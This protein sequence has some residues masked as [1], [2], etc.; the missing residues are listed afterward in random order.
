[1][2]VFLRTKMEAKLSE[3]ECDGRS[4]SKEYVSSSC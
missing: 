1:M 2:D 3:M 4:R